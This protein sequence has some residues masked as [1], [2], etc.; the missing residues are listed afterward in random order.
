[1]TPELRGAFA[2]WYERWYGVS[3][4]PSCEIQPLMGSK[5]GI[6]IIT[7]AF[8]NEGDKVL[9][10]DPG[11]PT[12]TTAASLAGARIVKYDLRHDNG[13][14]P[15]FEALEKED[16][17]GVKIM[18]TNYPNMPTGAPASAELY[19]KIADFAARHK[20]LV[21]NDNPYSFIQN[22]KPLS[23]LAAK[24]ARECCLEMNSLSKAHNM[25]GWRVGMVG[26]NADYIREILKVKS[27]M[28][29]GMF[30]PLQLAAATALGEG[31][32]W[33]SDLNSEYARRKAA[34]SEIFDTL[35]VSYDS[36]SQGLFLWGRV[37]EDN[38][39]YVKAAS[40]GYAVEGKTRGEVVSDYILYNA[41]VFI[42]PGF[43]FG[44]NGENY[45]RASLCADVPTLK[46]A[47]GLIKNIL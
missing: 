38:P 10:P 26:G 8:V 27:Q 32:D 20:I 16:L 22:D 6:L 4:D 24:G 41:F 2:K 35:G 42:T 23:L 11:Y 19:Q 13:W 37:D 40:K 14:Y 21:I 44:H 43:V 31:P 18:W 3:L 28:D 12:Y 25:S 29:S 45:I 46:R 7:L 1:G 17:S 39:A 36:G 33:F 34:A 5:E 9:I 30:R 47:C 15:D